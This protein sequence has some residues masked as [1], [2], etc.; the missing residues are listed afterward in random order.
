MKTYLEV[1]FSSDKLSSELMNPNSFFYAAC[2]GDQIIAY[3]KVNFENAQ[4]DRQL[5][6]AMEIERIY[7]LRDFHGKEVGELLLKK[8][9]EVAEKANVKKIWLG[10]WENNLRAIRFYEKHGFRAYGSHIFKLGKDEQNDI[11]M[12]LEG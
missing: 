5:E 9:K 11:L 4:S 8:A 3:L 12:K 10:V 1:E 6:N 7:V 2:N